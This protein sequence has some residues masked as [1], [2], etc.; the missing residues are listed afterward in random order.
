MYD[1]QYLM[2]EMCKYKKQ[3]LKKK[4]TLKQT[5]GLSPLSKRE[6]EW[7]EKYSPNFNVIKPH[8]IWR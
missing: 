7:F 5:S 3:K 1:S 6:Y 4:K 2:I 8:I